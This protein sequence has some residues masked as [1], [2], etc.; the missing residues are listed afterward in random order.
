MKEK[1]KIYFDDK[2]KALGYQGGVIPLQSTRLGGK[3]ASYLETDNE[4]LFKYALKEGRDRVL[5]SI[6]PGQVIPTLKE[7]Q[8][9]KIKI[10]EP[11]KPKITP[12]TP[13]E[14]I[15]EPEIDTTK[16]IEIN[17]IITPEDK[18][19]IEPETEIEPEIDL[20]SMAYFKLKSFAF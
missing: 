11:V 7:V 14:I 12:L 1:Y 10:N 20:D 13:P 2:M 19:E 17:K 18:E 9:G 16:P 3:P 15:T 6:D 8:S 5:K 4:N